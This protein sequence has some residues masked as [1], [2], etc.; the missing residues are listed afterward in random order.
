MESINKIHSS[1]PAMWR[2]YIDQ[3][4]E[5]AR[6]QYKA[7]EIPP[8][9]YFCDNEK[10]ADECAELVVQGIKQATAGSLWSYK[11]HNYAFPKIGEIY[12]VTDFKGIA[13]AVVQVVKIEQTAFNEI[14]PQFAEREGEGDKSL[15]YWKRVHQAFFEREMADSGDQFREDMIIVC[16]YFDTVF[17]G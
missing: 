2:A 17:P 12:I 8:S 4:D 11:K 7:E 9:Y 1:V 6:S 13:K 15:A 5:S 10:D 16:E 14:T 3:L